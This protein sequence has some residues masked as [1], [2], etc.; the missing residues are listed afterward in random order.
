M[1]RTHPG[2]S[3]Q[4]EPTQAP[5]APP[6]PTQPLHA[7]QARTRGHPAPGGTATARASEQQPAVGHRR[8][9][10]GHR[11]D[12]RSAGALEPGRHR[13][14]HALPG[15]AA[16][17][18]RRPPPLRALQAH[19][20]GRDEQD[21]HDWRKRV[22]SLY[23]ALDMLGAKKAKG[24]RRAHSPRRPPW[25]SARQR[26]RSVDAVYLRRSSTLRP[27]AQTRRPRTSC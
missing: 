8:G 17:L 24:A 4:P 20:H 12:A 3:M 26:A 2:P 13:L 7:G 18:P 21:V 9:A 19:E 23:Y 27:S 10:C 15:P 6:E 14:R 16:H 1:P 25:R 5:F 22:K 11:R